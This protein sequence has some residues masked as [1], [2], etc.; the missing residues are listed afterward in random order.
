VCITELKDYFGIYLD[1]DL[2]GELS[3]VPQEA[4]TIY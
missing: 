1:T 4:G 3:E 2:L